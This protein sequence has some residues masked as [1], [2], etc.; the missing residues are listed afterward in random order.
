MA[1]LLLPLSLGGDSVPPRGGGSNG[2][3]GGTRRGQRPGEDRCAGVVAHP[4]LGRA[5]GPPVAARVVAQQRRKTQWGRQARSGKG[6]WRGTA[7]RASGERAAACYLP[8]YL[9]NP[10]FVVFVDVPQRRGGKKF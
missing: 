2:A 10:C 6:G 4:V 7:R 9:G 8:T 1:R 5:N 3:G